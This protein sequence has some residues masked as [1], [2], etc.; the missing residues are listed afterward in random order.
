MFVLQDI[1]S[2]NDV[3]VLTD[4]VPLLLIYSSSRARDSAASMPR[5]RPLNVPM[6][7]LHESSWVDQKGQVS[8]GGVASRST[9]G[10]VRVAS[11]LEVVNLPGI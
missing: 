4:S 8:S 10:K 9:L 5:N 11:L 2:V 1:P 6:W 7:G 3:V